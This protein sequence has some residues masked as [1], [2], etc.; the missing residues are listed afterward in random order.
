MNW[1]GFV[2]S[3]KLNFVEFIFGIVL[4]FNISGFFRFFSASIGIPIGIFTFIS[5]FINLLFILFYY[6]DF[7]LIIRKKLVVL[8]LFVLYIWPLIT[9]PFSLNVGLTE[10][11]RVIFFM[12]L[13]ISSIIYFYRIDIRTIDKVFRY[14]LLITILGGLLSLI[15]PNLF[16]P[17][18]RALGGN[19][20]LWVHRRAF[21][22]EIQANRLA[23]NSIMLFLG[24]FSFRSWNS[25]SVKVAIILLLFFCFIILTGSRT[26]M[27][28]FLILSLII[29]LFTLKEINKFSLRLSNYLIMLLISIF[30][31][32]SFIT[33]IITL[34]PES[35]L[36]KR[37]KSVVQVVEKDKGNIQ[38]VDANISVKDAMKDRFDK[39]LA[40]LKKIKE[41]P[42]GYGFNSDRYYLNNGTLK[43]TAHSELITTAFQ[44]GVIYPIFLIWIMSML[45]KNRKKN[46]HKFNTNLYLQFFIL[47]IMLYTFAQGTL[48][49][50]SFIV[51]LSFI[52][53][54]YH[55]PAKIKESSNE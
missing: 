31:I 30:L 28:L 47:F 16:L 51:T 52:V 14:G 48:I 53:Y 7:M 4:V 9:I 40:Y 19:E 10:V 36:S 46:E 15:A 24:W 3:K 25:N 18:I 43:M 11:A 12:S 1:K 41:K 55:F 54:I 21:G 45:L 8:L 29:V 26:G 23:C 38:E 34:H 35:S 32:F 17:T 22:F 2:I 42:I 33:V 6:K 37:M 49:S 5:L 44:F 50:R 13:F 39:Q 20:W 27:G